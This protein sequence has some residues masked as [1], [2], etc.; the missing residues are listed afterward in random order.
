[1]A[2]TQVLEPSCFYHIYNRGINSETLFKEERNYSYFLEK[3]NY[4]LSPV[5]NTLAYCLLGNHFHFLIQIKNR[6]ELK[7]FTQESKTHPKQGL[8]STDFVVSKQFAKH[9]SSYTQ[10]INKAFGRTGS[11]FESP[12]NRIKVESDNYLTQLIKYIHFNPQ[13]HG[14]VKDFRNYPHSSY[15]SHLHSEPTK[16]SRKLV[17]EWFGNK[18]GYEQVHG[19]ETN[20]ESIKK[21]IIEPLPKF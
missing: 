10:A 1:M 15:Q 6:D 19:D 8:H 9:F 13:K 21:L 11:L 4:Y 17:L 7:S 2:T 5:A 12:F 20:Y 14:F 16:L 18:V 3:Y